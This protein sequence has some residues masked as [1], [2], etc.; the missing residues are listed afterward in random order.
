MHGLRSFIGAY[1][2]LARVLP[3][4]ALSLAPVE[5]AISGQLSKDKIHWTDE[6][7]EHFHVAQT[8][9]RDNKEIYLP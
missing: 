6:L 5:N 2:V 4:Y 9:L 1:K 7:T 3:S 8:K